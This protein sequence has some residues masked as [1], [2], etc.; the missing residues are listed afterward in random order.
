MAGNYSRTINDRIA[1]TAA[2]TTVSRFI[3][4]GGANRVE[5]FWVNDSGA[6]MSVVVKSDVMK[7]FVYPNEITS[8]GVPYYYRFLTT[9]GPF[10]NYGT[11]GGTSVAATGATTVG[12][13]DFSF[14]VADHGVTAL[15]MQIKSS[16]VIANSSVWTVEATVYNGG[17]SWAAAPLVY[18][19]FNAGVTH[20]CYAGFDSTGHLLIQTN[21]G[22]GTV[23]FIGTNV[24]PLNTWLHCV[25]RITSG[26][27]ALYVNGVLDRAAAYTP[28]LFADTA[29]ARFG[30]FTASFTIAEPSVL[31]GTA[32]LADAILQHY[33]DLVFAVNLQ[34]IETIALATGTAAARSYGAGASNPLPEQMEIDYARVAATDSHCTFS[35]THYR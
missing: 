12:A 33:Q 9:S 16:T 34:T 30:A 24:Q 32:V 19:E 8:Q 10:I 14:N 21:N 18:Q 11:A 29:T 1:V 6:D 25:W 35:G 5:Y 7:S 31:P 27:A 22:A 2:N 17:A 15:T 3:T 28:A 13:Q 4:K 26:V 20:I 23:S